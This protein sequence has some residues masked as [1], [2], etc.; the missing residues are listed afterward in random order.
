MSTIAFLSLFFGLIAGPYPVELA[1][2]G[3]VAAVEL[4][5]DSRVVQTLQGPPWK[6]EIDFG[7]D[8]QPH[9]IVARALDAKGNE[10]ARTQDWANLPHPLAKVDVVLEREKLGSPKAAKVVW[11]DLKGE[12]PA[13]RLLTFDGVPVTLDAAGRAVLPPHDL[14]SVHL[15]AAEVDFPSGRLARKEIAYGGEYGTEVS[16][17]LTAV[18]VRVRQGKLPPAWKLRGW[19]TAGGRPLAVAAVEEGPAQLYVVRSPGTPKA[20]WNLGNPDQDRATLRATGIWARM[21]LGAE[22]EVRFVFPFSQRFE[23]SGELSDLFTISTDLRSRGFGLPL[24]LLTV[25]GLRAGPGVPI[26]FADAVAVTALEATAES[27][28]RAVLLVVSAQEKDQSRYDPARVRRYLAALRVP[29]FVWCVGEPEPGSAAAAWGKVEVLKDEKD[30]TRA[31]AALQESLDAQ[32]IVMVDGHHLPQSIALSPK[33]AGVEL[34]GA[35]P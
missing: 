21:K 1:A 4:R 9:E 26:R 16:T 11:T 30:L 13:A 29:L 18:P 19:L 25:G 23:G 20:L 32:R 2:S 12:K 14:K 33:A 7:A 27:R 31:F 22:D 24:L 6:T 17:E 35:T 34:A 8:L 15:I 5:M 28:R 10:V 3:P